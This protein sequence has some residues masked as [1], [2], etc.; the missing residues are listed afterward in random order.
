MKLEQM[1][2]LAVK[3]AEETR[4]LALRELEH[5]D[6][7][8]VLAQLLGS[9]GELYSEAGKAIALRVRAD[10]AKQRKVRAR[11]AGTP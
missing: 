7:P 5:G 10:T 4:G 1:E 6:D 11:K 3:E 8:I 2:Q 9:M